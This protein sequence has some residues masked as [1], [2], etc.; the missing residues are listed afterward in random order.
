MTKKIYPYLLLFFFISLY[1]L[2]LGARKLVV[3]DET[4]YA[5]IPREMIESND[6]VVPHFNGLRY[7]EKPVLGY[8]VHACSLVLFGENNFAIRLPSALSVGLSAL[9]IYMLIFKVLKKREKEKDQISIVAA[10][11]FLSSFEVFTIANSPVLDNLFSFFLTASIVSFYFASEA[12][13]QSGKEKWFLILSGIAC[14]LAFL[15][16]GFLA[17]AIPV[18]VLAPYLIWQKRY[19]DLFRMTWL[20]ILSAII[21]ALPWSILIHLRE[22]DYWR[23]FFWHEHI[24]RF[25]AHNAQHKRFFL[26]FFFSSPG[27]FLPWFFLIPSAIIGLKEKLKP[28]NSEAR[29]VRFSIC[30]FVFPFLFFSFSHGKLL[31]YVLPCF[32]PFAILMAFGL[33]QIATNPKQNKF[34]QRGL[35]VNCILF[36]IFLVVFSVLQI[37]GFKGA[38]LYSQTWKTVMMINSLIFIILFC[39]WSFQT[40]SRIKKIFLYGFSPFLLFLCLNFL[41][42]D[43]LVEKKMPGRLLENYARTIPKDAFVVTDQETTGGVCWYLKRNDIYILGESG[44]HHYGLTYADSKSQSLCIE[45]LTSLIKNNPGKVIIICKTNKVQHWIKFFPG[46]VFQD[47]SGP[48]GY[49]LMKY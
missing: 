32:P 46:P 24:R 30:W 8:W 16:K 45:S 44:E 18:I 34:F 11:I 31:T 5:E 28:G 9:L 47:D 22:P 6:W 25:L 36:I 37:I 33:L 10:F 21:V 23:F 43:F 20:P 39:Y 40:Q 4:R 41:L 12:S 14:G 35:I 38:P 15:T 2:P 3:P 49:A 13:K 7:F 27:I 1:I 42:P 48:D 19:I 26:Y 17:F 29:L